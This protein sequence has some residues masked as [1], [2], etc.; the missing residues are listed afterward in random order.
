MAS[1]IND[2]DASW[3]ARIRELRDERGLSATRLARMADVDHTHLRKV[4][5]GDA[6]FGDDARIRLARAL[7]V[8]VEEIFVYPD[9]RQGS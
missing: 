5:H 2:L 9:T 6:R 3:G 1:N 7:G 4:E 8:R